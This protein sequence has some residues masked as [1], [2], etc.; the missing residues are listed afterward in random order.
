M[1]LLILTGHIILVAMKTILAGNYYFLS[2]QNVC[3]YKLGCRS[4]NTLATVLN[5]ISLERAVHQHSSN[6]CGVCI[7]TLGVELGVKMCNT[8][9][10]LCYFYH[11]LV[12]VFLNVAAIQTSYNL[13]SYWDADDVLFPMI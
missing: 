12:H 1:T 6:V 2:Y 10:I 9:D 13:F 5:H 3:I 4:V 8:N 7:T 11:I